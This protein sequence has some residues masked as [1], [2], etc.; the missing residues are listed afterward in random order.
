MSLEEQVVEGAEA[1]AFESRLAQA[2]WDDQFLKLVG[3]EVYRRGLASL[4]PDEAQTWLREWAR[5]FL[6]PGNKLTTPVTV[7]DTDDGVLLRFL[8]I[9][10]LLLDRHPNPTIRSRRCCCRCLACLAQA[11]VLAL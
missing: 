2:H 11:T 7:Q 1:R 4:S 6:R 8:T 5:R 10:T 3:P 9:V